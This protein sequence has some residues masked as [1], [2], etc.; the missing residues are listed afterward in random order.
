MTLVH[1][2]KKR[3]GK[4]GDFYVVTRV[5]AHKNSLYENVCI[6]AKYNIRPELEFGQLETIF[7]NHATITKWKEADRE[8]YSR[9]TVHPIC[10]VGVFV[11][12]EQDV[13]EDSVLATLV[14]A[15]ETINERLTTMEQNIAKLLVASLKWSE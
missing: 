15:I 7:S 11:E 5:D 14:T 10:E 6:A 13:D 8:Y 1:V 9:P 12:D 2:S 3:T 4:Y